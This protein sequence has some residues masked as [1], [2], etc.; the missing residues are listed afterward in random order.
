MVPSVGI[1]LSVDQPPSLKTKGGSRG[2]RF[3]NYTSN[4]HERLEFLFQ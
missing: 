3:K 4:A 1:K 2:K